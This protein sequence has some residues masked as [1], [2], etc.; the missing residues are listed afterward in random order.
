[1]ECFSA[2]FRICTPCTRE[3]PPRI[4][5]A[6]WTA[7]VI[8]PRLEPFS[9]QARVIGVDAVGTLDRVRHREGDQR[10][11]P[12]R[13]LPLLEDFGVVVEELLREFRRVLPDL[14]ELREI[15]GVVIRL[16][17]RPPVPTRMTRGRRRVFDIMPSPSEHQPVGH[18]A[19]MLLLFLRILR[20]HDIFQALPS[21]GGQSESVELPPK[22]VARPVPRNVPVDARDGSGGEEIAERRVHRLVLLHEF[23]PAP[24]HILLVI[25]LGQV[26]PGGRQDLRINRSV[27]PD[28]LAAPRLDRHALS[29]RRYGERSRTCIAASRDAP[30]DHG[31]PRRHRAIPRRRSRTDRSPPRPSRCGSR[32]CDTWG[33]PS[34]L[35]CTRRGCGERR[36]DSRTGSPDPRISPGRRSPSPSLRAGM[37]RSAVSPRIDAAVQ[38]F[39]QLF[40]VI[41]VASKPCRPPARCEMLP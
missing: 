19:P 41:I 7:S 33:S 9:R 12:L 39:H 25:R 16:H 13:K 17:S 8:S 28:G 11:L 26:E 4:A 6:T 3:A 27:S 18:A 30:E 10:L 31:L 32:G 15:G 24:E 22:G 37:H 2:I 36:R 35:P 14:A 23:R 5:A 38:R 29:V 20:T 40:L 21:C 34:I 1:M